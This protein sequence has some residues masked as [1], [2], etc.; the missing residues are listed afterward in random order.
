MTGWLGTRVLPGGVA[1]VRYQAML[2]LRQ[3]LVVLLLGFG[4]AL[5]AWS[6]ALTYLTPGTER[7]TLFDSVYLTVELLAVLA[8]LLG[9]VVLQILEFDQR[10]AWLVLVRPPSRGAYVWGRFWGIV[11]ASWA[12][13]GAVALLLLVLLGPLGGLPEPFFVPVFAAAAAE[14]AVIAAL[15][16]LVTFGTTAYLTSFLVQLG[17]VGLGYL[18]QVLPLLAAKAGAPLRALVWALYGVLPHLADF[19]VRD[20]AEPPEAWYVLKLAGYAVLYSAAVGALALAA[21][22]RRDF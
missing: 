15:A 22:R 17:V 11:L 21:F 18:S 4:A 8:P 5:V 12:V 20:F 14:S 3:R 19:A 16:C 9:S 13:L 10:T 7:R 1:L 2:V 6:V